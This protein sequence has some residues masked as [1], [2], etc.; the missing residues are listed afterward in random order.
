MNSE[1]IA[2]L[3][4]LVDQYIDEANEHEDKELSLKECDRLR[5]FVL[6]CKMVEPEG[7]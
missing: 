6:Y 1:F 4:V 5:D 2:K 7:E 3:E